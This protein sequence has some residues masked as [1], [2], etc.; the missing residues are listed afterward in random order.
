M[1]LFQPQDTVV[2][3]QAL[4]KF[5]AL[6]YSGK[7]EVTVEAKNEKTDHTFTVTPENTLLYQSAAVDIA[8]NGGYVDITTTGSGCAMV[9]VGI[10]GYFM[11]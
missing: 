6:T 7:T 10:M 5:A 11:F 3:L 1:C 8:K 4:S 9:Q 2:A